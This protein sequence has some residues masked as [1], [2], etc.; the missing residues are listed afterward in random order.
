MSIYVRT[1]FIIGIGWCLEPLLRWWTFLSASNAARAS[2]RTVLR[3]LKL[4][5]YLSLLRPSIKTKDAD[6]THEQKYSSADDERIKSTRVCTMFDVSYVFVSY[7][8]TLW[9]YIILSTLFYCGT[10][11]SHNGMICNWDVTS[12]PSLIQ[13]CNFS[14]LQNVENGLPEDA[15]PK[16]CESLWTSP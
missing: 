11:I 16:T 10:H 4:R 7:M 2:C 15:F 6:K 13:L 12:P 3:R 14:C 9:F 8:F 1:Y 5:R